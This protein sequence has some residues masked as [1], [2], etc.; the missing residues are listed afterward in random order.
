M[1]HSN[2]EYKLSVCKPSGAKSRR[3]DNVL[4]ISLECRLLVFL[5]SYWQESDTSQGMADDLLS[6]RKAVCGWTREARKEY[7]TRKKPENRRP[8]TSRRRAPNALSPSSRRPKKVHKC[9]TFHSYS[10]SNVLFSRNDE[11]HQLTEINKTRSTISLVQ[12]LSIIS[13]R[14]WVQEHKWVSRP[15]SI[16]ENEERKKKKHKLTSN[17]RQSLP[18]RYATTTASCV[19]IMTTQLASGRE[20][21]W[22]VTL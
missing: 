16:W 11:P 15:T 8:V 6:P 5:S 18:S 19:F 3:R 9:F 2:K 4:A 14:N 22:D 12:C 17:T 20:M 13:Y 7:K 1:P 10:H 21:S